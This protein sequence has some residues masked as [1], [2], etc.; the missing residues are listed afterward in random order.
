MWLIDLGMKEVE[1]GEGGGTTK[2]EDS[3]SES[4]E[5]E[6][7]SREEKMWEETEEVLVCFVLG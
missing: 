2:G 7:E 6:S 3:V 5:S 1:R 4:E